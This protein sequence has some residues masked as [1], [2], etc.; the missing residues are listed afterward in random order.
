MVNPARGVPCNCFS[1]A[2]VFYGPPRCESPASRLAEERTRTLIYLLRLYGR[3]KFDMFHIYIFWVQ[4]VTFLYGVLFF[5]GATTRNTQPCGLTANFTSIN[6]LAQIWKIALLICHV[7]SCL[8]R[9]GP[10]QN[11]LPPR[12]CYVTT[13]PKIQNPV[14]LLLLNVV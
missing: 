1:F 5:F 3:V 7:H 11:S 2:L 8:W 6:T 12:V 10:K 13:R 4:A 14:Y 9:F